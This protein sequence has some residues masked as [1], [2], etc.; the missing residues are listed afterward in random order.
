[1]DLFEEELQKNKKKKGIKM[2]TLIVIAIIILFILCFVILGAISYLRGTILTITLD[3]TDASNLKE[4]LIFEEDSKI[5]IPIRKM[6]E[7]LKYET[8]NGDYITL[9][10][11]AT[12]CYIRNEEELVS[13]ALDS[14]VITKVIDGQTQQIKINEPIVQIENELYISSEGA[15]EAFN[16]YFGFNKLKNVITINTLSSLYDSYSDYFVNKGYVAIENET[17]NNKKAIFDGFIIIKGQNGKYG[18]MTTENNSKV[19]LETKYESINYLDET[20]DFLVSS[21]NKYGITSKDKETKVSISYDSIQKVTNKQ[22]IFYIVKKS[23][24]YGLLDSNGKTIIYPEYT[25]IGMDVSSYSKNGV[26]D[27]N[28][29]YNEIIPVNSNNKWALFNIKGEKLTDFIYDGFGSQPK[30]NNSYGVLEVKEYKLIIGRQGQKYDLVTTNG[31]N[32]FKAFILDSVYITENSGIANYYIQY[33]GQNI[34]LLK[35]L[36]ENNV[37]KPEE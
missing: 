37:K 13:F 32:L 3:G 9:S 29:F 28:I 16:F 11:D 5:Y 8:Y 1:M 15:Q 20:S 31:E 6:G 21:N 23:N 25:K 12:K 24:Q 34:E 17:L 26:T 27:G 18:V 33:G 2:S 22:E 4:I 14:N 19:I 35:F 36:E 30:E 10:E 7:Y